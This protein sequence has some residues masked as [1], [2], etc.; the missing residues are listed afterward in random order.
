VPDCNLNNAAKNGECGAM[1]D[2]SLGQEVLTKTYDPSFVNGWGT[3]PYN[4]GL[5]V[6]VQQELFPRV[7]MT[8]GYFRNWWGNWYVWDNRATTLADYTPFSI[9]A[10]LDPRLPGGGGQVISGLYDLVPT[11][12]GQVDE[13][14][15]HL[16]NFGEATE[17]WQ[18]VDVGV[19]ARLR[20]G[21]TLQGGTSTGRRAEDVCA[22]K[23]ALPEYGTGPAGGSVISR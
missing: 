12:V 22:I 8:V 14:A 23:A 18:G 21:L 7:S 11:K 17:N 10:P 19:V 16:T 5:G 4:W 2:Q 6:S 13:L 20:N 3:R 1:D 9:T 15:Q